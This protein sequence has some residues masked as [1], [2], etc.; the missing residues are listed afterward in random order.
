[1]KD[2]RLGLQFVE[3]VYLVHATAC[4]RNKNG[5]GAVNFQQGV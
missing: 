1:M 3:Q 4:N 5:D 2:P